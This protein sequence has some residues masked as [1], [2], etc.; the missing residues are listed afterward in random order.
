M[1][2]FMISFARDEQGQDLVEYALLFGLISLMS[3]A[4]ITAYGAKISQTWSS[5]DST[6]GTVAGS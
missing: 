2:N 5:L 6:I 3:A 4:S 1:K